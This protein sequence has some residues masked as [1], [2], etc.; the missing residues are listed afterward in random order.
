[1]VEYFIFPPLALRITLDVTLALALWILNSILAFE[2]QLVSYNFQS[3]HDLPE[4]LLAW[5]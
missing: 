3:Y 5:L 4:T 1:M 2:T